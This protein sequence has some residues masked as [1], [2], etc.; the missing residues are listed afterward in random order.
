MIGITATGRT[1]R[2]HGRA[3]RFIG[4]ANVCSKPEETRHVRRKAPSVVRHGYLDGNQGWPKDCLRCVPVC[5]LAF[6]IVG[7]TCWP[8]LGHPAVNLVSDLTRLADPMHVNSV[9][10][11]GRS[12]RK[13]RDCGVGYVMTKQPG[14]AMDQKSSVAA[15]CDVGPRRDRLNPSGQLSARILPQA[16]APSLS[17]T[18]FTSQTGLA[19]NILLDS[20][21]LNEQTSHTGGRTIRSLNAKLHGTTAVATQSEKP[22]RMITLA[23]EGMT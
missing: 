10:L 13:A 8:C 9:L 7:L 17:D 18:N 16:G 14:A 5:G 1:C 21:G 23:V 20:C 22:L 2:S 4:L 3:T 19:T 15:Q 11:C 12:P 6:W